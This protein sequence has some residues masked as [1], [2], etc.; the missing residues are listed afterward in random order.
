MTAQPLR[1]LVCDHRGA[2]LEARFEGLVG[3]GGPPFETRVSRSVRDSVRAVSEWSPD[4]VVLDPLTKGIVTEIAALDRADGRT[5]GRPEPPAPFL[6]LWDRD[7]ARAARRLA[8]ELGSR[9]WDLVHRD[10]TPEEFDVRLRQLLGYGRMLQEMGRLRHR[11]VHDDRTELLRPQA[12]QARLNEHFAAAK[13]HQL[14]LAFVMMDLDKFGQINKRYDHT[15]GDALIARVGEVIR[16]SLRTEDVAGRLGGDEF[17][18]L[19]PYTGKVDAV[20]VVNRL[21]ERIQALSGRYE[22]ASEDI[23]V[24]TSI[25]FETFD[26]A[27]LDSVEELRR[28]AERA[29]RKAKTSGG[30]RAIYFR[31]MDE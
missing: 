9:P 15:V 30:D 7:E 13:R 17:A 16:K 14:E 12:F 4:L 20:Q 27:D 8:D 22:G 6:V 23:P 29:L 25:G 19:L 10:A 11:A 18:V 26:G 24:S 1:I 21:R 28:R 3:A 31:Q 5:N 2:G